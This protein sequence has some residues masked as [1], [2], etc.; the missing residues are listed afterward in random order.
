MA[1]D[2]LEG[3][4]VHIR[5]RPA[6]KLRALVE[7][8][9]RPLAAPARRRAATNGPSFGRLRDGKA[10]AAA[11]NKS[12]KSKAPAPSASTGR[13]KPRRRTRPP[14][15]PPAVDGRTTRRAPPRAVILEP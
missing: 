8:A 11:S 1:N 14:G 4:Q 2:P 3:I 5:K 7:L 9:T 12:A 10:S 6:A 15:V 13:A